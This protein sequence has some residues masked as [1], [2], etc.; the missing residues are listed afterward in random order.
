MLRF[1]VLAVIAAAT[2]LA[3][4]TPIPTPCEPVRTHNEQGKLSLSK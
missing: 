1:I 3:K 2:K 4:P